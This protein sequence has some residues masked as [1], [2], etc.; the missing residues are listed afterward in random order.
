MKRRPDSN[1]ANRGEGELIVL[2]HVNSHLRMPLML[3][4]MDVSL[5]HAKAKLMYQYRYQY[6]VMFQ[7]SQAPETGSGRDAVVREPPR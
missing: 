3:F 1:M 5:S 6:Q 2:R 7:P 4:L